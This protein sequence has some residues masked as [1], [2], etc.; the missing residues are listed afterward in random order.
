VSRRKRQPS[1]SIRRT[2]ATS[3]RRGSILRP[4]SPRPRLTDSMPLPI[5]S[6]TAAPAPPRRRP[7]NRCAGA[8]GT[9]CCPPLRP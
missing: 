2:C 7:L 8:P 1:H 3:V 9:R 5:S 6:L 4:A